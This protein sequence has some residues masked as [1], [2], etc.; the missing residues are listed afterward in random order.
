M[1]TKYDQNNKGSYVVINTKVSPIM[2]KVLE[3]IAERVG[4]KPYRFI[5]Q[6]VC[7]MI[8]YM[9]SSHPL[10]PE[11]EQL[12][13]IFLADLAKCKTSYNFADP[14]AQAQITDAI[15]II[16]DR[17]HAEGRQSVAVD[18][19]YLNHATENWNVMQQ[20]EMMICKVL[21]DWYRKLRIL[22]AKLDTRNV[23]ET[24]QTV[25]NEALKDDPDAEYL[26]ELFSDNQNTESGKTLTLDHKRV[27]RP[28]RESDTPTLFDDGAQ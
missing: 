16:G 7:S 10:T 27:R 6:I 4:V 26:R 1:K 9:D 25:I 14:T 28:G 3:E 15:F 8:K 11:L 20:L 22:G 13:Q 5:Q 19:P 23:Y 21:P 17:K 24:L 18:S 12:M 2:A